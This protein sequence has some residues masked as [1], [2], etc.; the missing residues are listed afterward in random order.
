V[1]QEDIHALESIEKLHNY[2]SYVFNKIFKK[3]LN[4]NT[5]DFGCGYGTLISYL[6]TKFN[7]EII[8]FEINPDA[9]E[10]L[11]TKKIN[12]INSL[13]ENKERFDQVVSLN[14]LEHIENDQKTIEDINHLLKDNGMLVLYLP[15]SMKI[16]TEL[17]ELVG[18]YRRYTKKDLFTKLENANF[19]I[20]SW[21]Y[22]DFIGWMALFVSKLLG[23][24]LDYKENRLIRYDK[25]IFRFLKNLD[26]I[27]KYFLGKN[28]LVTCIKKKNQ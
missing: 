9:I 21:E 20:Q 19:E 8:G 3:G 11:N 16:W 5:L 1:K 28:I 24:K 26:Y 17:D 4:Q 27:F 15:H 23:V 25:Y 2:N 22:V 7:L 10:K 13:D 18:H 14:V 6:K 12:L